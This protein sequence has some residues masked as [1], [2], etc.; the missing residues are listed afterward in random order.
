M[1][2]PPLEM[3]NIIEFPV[4]P[5]LKDQ[6]FLHQ[7][8]VVEGLSTSQIAEQISSSK[9]AVAS[10]LKRLGVALRYPHLPHG[11]PAQPKFGRRLRRGRVALFPKEERVVGAVAELRSQ[12]LSLRQIARVMSQM[13]VPTKCNGQAWH[14]EMVR[15]V[16]ES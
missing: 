7:K 6:A 4:T 9:T 2:V 1:Q 16:L 12:G 3:T 15:R 8:Y 13:K 5:K 10:A 14:P 11:H